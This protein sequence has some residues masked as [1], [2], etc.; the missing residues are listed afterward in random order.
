[1]AVDWYGVDAANRAGHTDG[2]EPYI[3]RY[4][5]DSTHA[6]VG[7]LPSLVLNFSYS[8]PSAVTCCSTY[9]IIIVTCTSIPDK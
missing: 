1:M 5:S 3:N 7:D 2:H 4:E 9:I 8:L 6:N